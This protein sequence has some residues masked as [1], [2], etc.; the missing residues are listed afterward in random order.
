MNQIWENKKALI[1]SLILV[2]LTQIC[3]HKFFSEVLHLLVVRY[4]TY[5]PMQ[6]KGKLMKQTWEN[7]KKANFAPDFDLFGPQNFFQGFTSTS[8]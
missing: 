4:W 6:F 7:N 1:L 2:C 8:S 3:A 5:H